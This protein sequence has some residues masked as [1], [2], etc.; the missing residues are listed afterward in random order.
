MDRVVSVGCKSWLWVVMLCG[1]CPTRVS[2]ET[3]AASC[4]A[5]P[6]TGDRI[7]SSLRLGSDQ[8][9]WL[10]RADVAVGSPASIQPRPVEGP[11]SHVIADVTLAV[12]TLPGCA[13]CGRLRVGKDFLHVASLVGASMCSACLC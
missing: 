3:P 4:S 8:S 5:L 12:L 9:S 1:G 2:E 10:T 6:H 11:V 13:M 7:G